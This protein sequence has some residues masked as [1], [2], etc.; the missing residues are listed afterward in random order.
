[1]TVI[2]LTW[3]AE[4]LED[5]FPLLQRGVWLKA[6]L[7]LSIR[8]VLCDQLGITHEYLD[9][10][11]GTIFLD[12]SP[13]DDVDSAVVNEG[14]RLALSAAMPGLVGATMRKGGILASMRDSITHKAGGSGSVRKEG[15]FLVRLF[16][17]VAPELGPA[18]LKMGVQLEAEAL[19][20]FLRGASEELWTGCKNCLV[21]G[22]KVDCRKLSEILTS[23][24]PGLVLL[25]VESC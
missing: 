14:A 19:S 23:A 2:E 13:V 9:H 16:N 20:G 5:F 1:M 25:R 8:S 18:L 3:Q 21:D 17:M 4:K 22:S 15:F 24:A 12:G 11:I 7:G 10:R 6:Q